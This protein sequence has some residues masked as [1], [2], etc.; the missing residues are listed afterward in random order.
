MIFQILS[1]GLLLFS[2]AVLCLFLL[3]F[4]RFHSARDPRSYIFEP[5]EGYRP[6]YSIKRVKEAL[7]FISKFNK[8]S[9]RLEFSS[10]N[11]AKMICIGIATVKRPLEQNLDV[12][13]G[14][15][16]EGLSQK[17]LSAISLHVL[18]AHSNPLDHP[19]YSHPRVSNVVDTILTYETVGS[20]LAA[21]EVLEKQ[22]KIA[23]K[24][25]SD[26]RLTLKSCYNRTTALWIVILDDVL[27]QKNWYEHTLQ[28]L[29]TV[30]AWESRGV[31][32]SWL[33]LQLF[34]TEKLLGSNSEDWPVYLVWC[35]VASSLPTWV[36]VL[37]VQPM[38]AGVHLMNR[39]GCCSQ[40]LLFP[41]EKVPVL[42]DYFEYRRTTSPKPVDSVIEALA[43]KAGFDRL[44]VSLS[45]MQH[46]G[47][48]SYKENR[49]SYTWKGPHTVRGAHDGT[50]Y[51]T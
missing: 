36:G 9:K 33:Y 38:R 5:N 20:P 23:E 29:Q 17:G 46:V 48:F 3:A 50:R 34:Y 51:M 12:T 47:A 32:K 39:F 19:V 14:S 2:H 44:A 37:T 10:G 27:A 22:Q 11:L 15:L 16:L 7:Q 28:S 8:P 24:S 40:A 49:K 41:R 30:R 6:Q 42:R 25:L 13:I 35:L 45:Q 1:Q 26:Y 31:I 4:C 18:F 43:D 21:H